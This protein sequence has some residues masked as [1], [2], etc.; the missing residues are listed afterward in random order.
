MWQHN[1]TVTKGHDIIWRL[2]PFRHAILFMTL[3]LW[4]H[5]WRL[6]FVIMYF[7]D[8][9]CTLHDSLLSSYSPRF[10][11]VPRASQRRM[12]Q[13]PGLGRGG[14]GVVIRLVS[15]TS[16]LRPRANRKSS[17]TP[18]VRPRKEW[19][20]RLVCRYPL[21]RSNKGGSGPFPFVYCVP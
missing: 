20:E 17:E 7:Y 21:L 18:W 10:F 19:A 16:E 9:F 11:V 14:D 13:F 8:N 2:L 4:R 6:V 3:F 1:I 15:E 12:M 5:A